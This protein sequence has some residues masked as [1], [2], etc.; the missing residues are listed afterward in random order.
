[1]RPIPQFLVSVVIASVLVFFGGAAATAQNMFP[2]SGN[3]GIGTTAPTG[4]LHVIG[5]GRT[6]VN[7]DAPLQNNLS[8]NFLGSGVPKL[9]LYRQATTGDLVIDSSNAADILHLT[10]MGNVG[11]GTATPL[12]NLHVSGP[13]R[14][15]LML[16]APMANSPLL[17]FLAGGQSRFSIFRPASTSDL[18]MDSNAM[19]SVLY[20]TNDGRVGVGTNNPAAKLHVTGGV[21]VDGNIAAKYQDVA[22]WVKTSGKVP[23]GTVVVIDTLERDRVLPSNTPY[24]TRVAG[25]VSENPGVLLGT[26]DEGKAKIAHSGRVKVRVDTSYGSIGVGDLLVTSPTPGYAMRSAPVEVGGVSIHRPGTLIGKALEPLDQGQ[27]EI[28][29]LLMLQ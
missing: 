3:V 11:I 20:L 2:A 24:D 7:F 21:Q 17:N 13:G 28:L 22:E 6:D 14:T 9:S 18:S 5:T 16:D 23:Y 29:V 10:S 26:E 4:V 8:L 25:V 12:A 15:T 1:M 27:G 19:P